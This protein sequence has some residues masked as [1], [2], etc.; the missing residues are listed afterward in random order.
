M[1][2]PTPQY[3]HAVF[4]VRVP[5]ADPAPAAWGFAGAAETDKRV[6]L[7]IVLQACVIQQLGSHRLNPAGRHVVQREIQI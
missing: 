1:P 4:T 2:Q 6:V 7:V 5:A 3:G